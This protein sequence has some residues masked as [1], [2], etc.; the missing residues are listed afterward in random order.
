LIDKDAEL[1]KKAKEILN[2]HR[3]EL[4]ENYGIDQIGVGYKVIA[5]NVTNK[6]ALIFY[7]KNKKKIEDLYSKKIPEE[8]EGIPTDVVAIPKGFRPR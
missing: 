5:G 4:K 3:Q 8:I 7:V 1:V 2:T 6:V